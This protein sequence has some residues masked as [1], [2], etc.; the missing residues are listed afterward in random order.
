VR[1]PARSSSQGAVEGFL[2]LQLPDFQAIANA[3]DSIRHFTEDVT[4]EFKRALKLC[5]FNGARESA[6]K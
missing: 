1:Q 6:K 2:K 4:D 3:E 5:F